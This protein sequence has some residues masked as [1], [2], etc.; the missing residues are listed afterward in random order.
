MDF[1]NQI[2]DEL[3]VYD[4]LYRKATVEELLAGF[5]ISKN[6]KAFDSPEDYLTEKDLFLLSQYYAYANIVESKMV[7]TGDEYVFD[8][9]DL[10]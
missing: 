4:K 9:E 6:V 3:Q 8:E 1:D 10:D 2:I 7:A 5:E